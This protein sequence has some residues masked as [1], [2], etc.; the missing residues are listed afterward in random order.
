MKDR[1]SSELREG[2][3]EEIV[4]AGTVF[5]GNREDRRAERV[6]FRGERFLPSGINLVDGDEETFAGGAEKAGKFFIKR[7]DSGLGIDDEN[8]QGGFGD[9]DVG[10]AKDLLRDKGFVVGNDAAGVDNFECVTAPFGFAIDTIAG[11]TGLIG[12][13]GA[14]GAGE[15]VE[16]RG[17]AD[18][19]ASDDDER[20][21]GL[22]HVR[23]PL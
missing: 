5:G 9:G 19:R 12:N 6:K 7:S 23:K 11:D 13:D 17:L 22:G 3:V 1:G 18:V 16:K 20:R 21:K 14:A 2:S 8:E 4:D 15:A 10:L